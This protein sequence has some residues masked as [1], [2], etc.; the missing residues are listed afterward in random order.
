MTGLLAVGQEV[1]GRGALNGIEPNPV[2]AHWFQKDRST[3]PTNANFLTLKA[4]LLGQAYGLGTSIPKEFRG[5]RPG[6]PTGQPK[7]RIQARIGASRAGLRPILSL[8]RPM[9]KSG[10]KF[11]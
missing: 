11:C 3:H 10:L 6:F 1:F 7:S 2:L 9:D 5:L 4:K 8:S